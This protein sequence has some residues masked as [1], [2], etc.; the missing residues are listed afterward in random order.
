VSEEEEEDD[1]AKMVALQV[2]QDIADAL[3]VSP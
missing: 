1:D 2:D 3:A